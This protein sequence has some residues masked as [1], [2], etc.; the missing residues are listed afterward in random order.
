MSTSTGIIPSKVDTC[1][2][3]IFVSEVDCSPSSKLA[4]QLS[5]ENST[6]DKAKFAKGN[7][8]LCYVKYTSPDKI[9][10]FSFEILRYT[11]QVPPPSYFFLD[12]FCVKDA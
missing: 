10:G 5:A 9:S 11:T 1:T 8:T 12:F 4:K 2:L 7:Y 3:N 6:F